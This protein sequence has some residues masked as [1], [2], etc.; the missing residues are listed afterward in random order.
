MVLSHV[1]SR[2]RKVHLKGRGLRCNWNLKISGFYRIQE[3]KKTLKE[4]ESR[5]EVAFEKPAETPLS[6]FLGWVRPV[7]G[8]QG[9]R[10]P[11]LTS[12]RLSS[13]NPQETV[14]PPL[15]DGGPSRPSLARNSVVLPRAGVCV[16]GITAPF[17]PKR[18]RESLTD[19]RV[20]GLQLRPPARL[21]HARCDLGNLVL[22]HCKPRG[23]CSW[24]PEVVTGPPRQPSPTLGNAAWFIRASRSLLD[25]RSYMGL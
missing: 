19:S 17:L 12:E 10:S 1:D 15:P 25:C 18:F 3:E 14:R 2:E 20:L 24:P 22:G 9:V 23:T 16:V 8:E 6:L 5:G 11:G 21:G 4:N 13:A 7:M